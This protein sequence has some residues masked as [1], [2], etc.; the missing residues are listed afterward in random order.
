MEKFGNGGGDFP[1]GLQ[2]TDL[3][4][5]IAHHV[6][7]FG[8]VALL[9]AEGVLLRPGL[10]GRDIDRAAR[11]DL[12]YGTTAALILVVGILRVFL[13]AKGAQYYLQNPWFW[14]KMAAFLVVGLL[15]I[16]PTVRFI[17]WRRR[18]SAEPTFVPPAAE[19]QSLRRLLRLESVAVVAILVF[20][21]AM[22]RYG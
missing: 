8:L 21:A 19:V 15:S 2:V 12:A 16:G 4:L 17:A 1:N 13:G 18:R 6:L 11:L 9:M 7:A 5:A 10:V 3:I 22:A 14:A 20:A